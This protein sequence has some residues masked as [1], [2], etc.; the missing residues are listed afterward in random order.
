MQDGDVLG[1]RDAGGRLV[2]FGEIEV[3]GAAVGVEQLLARHLERR[4]E[5]HQREDVALAGGE[6]FDRHAVDRGG[7]PEVAGRV[8]PP[9]GTREV[10]QL[11]SGQ[12]RN[13]PLPALLVDLLPCHLGDRRVR[14]EEVVHEPEPFRLPIPSDP[15]PPAAAAAP[16][17][18]AAAAPSPPASTSVTGTLVNR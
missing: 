10:D 6:A 17:P 2:E 1:L 12:R 11:A 15:S 3:G 14:T 5:L 13:Q 16:S 8:V 7:P 18:P 9:E 4:P